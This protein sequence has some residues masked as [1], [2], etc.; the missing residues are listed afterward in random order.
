ML[1]QAFAVSAVSAAAFCALALVPDRKRGAALAQAG[2]AGA[3][4]LLFVAIVA[5]ERIG[6]GFFLAAFAVGLISATVA[7]ML[8]H[9]YLGRFE[10]VWVARGVFAGVY[11][12][13]SALFGL[14]FLSL[15]QGV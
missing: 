14:V 11:L 5:G 10:Q 7:G 4:A 6:S 9:L 8:Y 2:L 13:L 3:G 1:G 12:F 15:I